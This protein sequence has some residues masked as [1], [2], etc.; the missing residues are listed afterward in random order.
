MS[1][2]IQ[3]CKY[4]YTKREMDSERNTY[5]ECVYIRHYASML[6]SASIHIYI[7]ERT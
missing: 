6:V 5:V 7:A 2:Q 1:G 4:A 3:V